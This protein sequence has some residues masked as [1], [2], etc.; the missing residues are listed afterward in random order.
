MS[1][2]EPSSVR[3][4]S[5]RSSIRRTAVVTDAPIEAAWAVKAC[6]FWR[7]TW[8]RHSQAVVHGDRDEDGKQQPGRPGPGVGPLRS[9][10]ISAPTRV[11]GANAEA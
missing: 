7:L 10:A 4:A 8:S 1:G 2:R 9:V 11:I 6:S 3:A 5:V